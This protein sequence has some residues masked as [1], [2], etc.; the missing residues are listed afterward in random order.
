MSLI[1]IAALAAGVA[2]LRFAWAC[3]G[4][5]RPVAIIVGW[6]LIAA[7]LAGW[8][9]RFADSGLAIATATVIA[10]AYVFLGASALRARREQTR[11]R[12]KGARA[13]LRAP[14]PQADSGASRKHG[15]FKK[16]ATF[17][18]AGPVA[19]VAAT[20]FSLSSM[21]LAQAFGAGEADAIVTAYVA[22]PLFWA[23]CAAYAV[24]DRRLTRKAPVIAAAMGLSALHLA[25]ST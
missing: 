16:G 2:A 12:S 25:L 24:I 14:S 4:N 19:G 8:A 21:K 15:A 1:I 5:L 10:A 17:M 23:A 22:F 20:M 7:G 13:S 3:E 6:G 11:V 9:A 18:L